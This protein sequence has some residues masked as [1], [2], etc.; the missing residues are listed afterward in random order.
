[1]LTPLKRAYISELDQFL[2][3]FDQ[4]HPNKSPA[5]QREIEK[6]ARLARLRDTS[7]SQIDQEII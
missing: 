2:Q 4:S 5:Q 1:M 3:D 7:T 6:H